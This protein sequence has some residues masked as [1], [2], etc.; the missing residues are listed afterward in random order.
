MEVR[1]GGIRKPRLGNTSMIAM[2]RANGWLLE[3]DAST[4]AAGV[5]RSLDF[6]QAAVREWY[7]DQM[8]HYLDD[9]VD[10]WWNDEGETF[11]HN[12]YYWTLAQQALA[13]KKD[14]NKRF[15]TINRSFSPGNQRLG[16]VTWTGDVDVSWAAL[17]QQPG[18]VLNWALAGS[19]YVTADTGGFNGPN[20]DP[21]LLTRWYQASA[22]MPLMRVHSTRTVT[23][24]FPFLYGDEAASAMRS[25]LDLRYQMVPYHY[26]LAHELADGGKPIFRPMIMEFVNETEVADSTSQWMDGSSVLVCPVLSA[27]NSTSCYLPEGEW[28]AFNTASVVDGG[29][30]LPLTKVGLS[31]IPL[32]VKAG[33]IIPLAA[34]AQITANLTNSP[35][36]I[37]VYGGD[38]A[39]FTLYEDD[40]ETNHYQTG[41]VKKTTFTW[42]DDK[43]E[44]SWRSVGSFVGDKFSQLVGKYFVDGETFT[45]NVTSF[46]NAGHMVFNNTNSTF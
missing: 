30:S 36:E 24:H 28:Y 34:T 21:L 37:Q 42:N 23:P 44:L 5:A 3:G 27:T 7:G 12:F 18:Y 10:F 31:T 35:L 20:V 39:T 33:S 15:F 41:G 2:A 25:A 29:T 8:R 22:F 4:G 1:F 11:Y 16:A 46:D 9:G 43:E 17:Q 45:F 40:G 6:S 14:S 19:P 32:Y 26:S 13:A 38:N